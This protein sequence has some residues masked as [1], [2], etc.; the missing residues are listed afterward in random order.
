LKWS[1]AY[2]HSGRTIAVPVKLI[3]AIGAKGAILVAQLFYWKDKG[4]GGEGWVYKTKKQLTSETG[5]SLKEQRKC[6]EEMKR[7]GVL[8]T[9]YDRLEH[10]LWYRIHTETLD[11][12]MDADSPGEVPF[13]HMPKAPAKKADGTGPKGR[14]AGAQR[15]G[16]H[17]DQRLPQENTQE[18]TKTKEVVVA[19]FVSDEEEK[20]LAWMEALR[21]EFGL[22]RTQ[23]PKVKSFMRERGERKRKR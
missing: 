2:E 18:T 7:K 12:I 8:E 20:F 15:A 13:G 23:V 21:N 14:S 19:P 22:S 17:I 5:I 10:R 3:H 4:I 11:E 6:V 16:R 9:R 1:E